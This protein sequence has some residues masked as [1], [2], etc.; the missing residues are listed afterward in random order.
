M[1]LLGEGVLDPVVDR[2]FPLTEA[3]RAHHYIQDRKN[4]GKIVL[5]VD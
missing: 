3:A 4:L 1:Q 2:T 5:T